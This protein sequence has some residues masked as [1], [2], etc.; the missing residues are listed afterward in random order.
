MPYKRRLNKRR[1]GPPTIVDLNVLFVGSPAQME[2][3]YGSLAAARERWEYL[4]LAHRMEPTCAQR[5]P[6][7]FWLT[8]P[9][10]PD[11]LRENTDNTFDPCD[12]D[13]ALARH[14]I[15]A[16]ARALWLTSRDPEEGP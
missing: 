7:V 6:E 16:Q 13:A 8:E 10:V 5:Y 1:L 11:E 4:R 2:H 14:E 12:P 3:I 9:G 15:F